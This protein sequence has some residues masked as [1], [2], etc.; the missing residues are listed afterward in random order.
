MLDI[1]KTKPPPPEPIKYLPD[2]REICNLKTEAGKLAYKERTLAMARRQNFRCCLC[3]QRMTA[4]EATFDHQHRRG[5][6]GSKTDDRIEVDGKRQNG[7]AHWKCNSE[8]GSRNVPYV[9]Q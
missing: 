1:Y 2:G 4:E 5:M 8:K 3:G 9:I 7:A 6:G